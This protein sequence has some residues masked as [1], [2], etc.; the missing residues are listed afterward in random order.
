MVDLKLETILPISTATDNSNQCKKDLPLAIEQTPIPETIQ[1]NCDNCDFVTNDE[2]VLAD[3]IKQMHT[4]SNDGS[5]EKRG[6]K[7][8][9]KDTSLVFDERTCR[10]C[11]QLEV[12]RTRLENQTAS[13]KIDIAEANKKNEA[14]SNEILTS[15]EKIE[16]QEQDPPM[17]GNVS[18]LQKA[19]KKKNEEYELLKQMVMD[20]DRNIKKIEEADKKEINIRLRK[21]Q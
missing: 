2:P 6:E 18:S 3:H 13:L 12:E 14:L 15:K 8:T 17:S 16:N 19:L 10:K 11:E 21:Q 4:I 1:I 7:R 5:P 9:R 20:Q